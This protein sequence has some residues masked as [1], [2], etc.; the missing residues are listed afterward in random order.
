MFRD[1]LYSTFCDEFEPLTPLP[2]GQLLHV[3]SDKDSQRFASQVL[4]FV[5]NAIDDNDDDDHVSDDHDDD[6]EEGEERLILSVDRRQRF[7]E[8]LGWGGAFTDAAGINI[9]SLSEGAQENLLRC[10]C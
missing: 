10:A 6:E 1:V 7:Q 3:A 5:N 9:A 2:A 8:V 4:N